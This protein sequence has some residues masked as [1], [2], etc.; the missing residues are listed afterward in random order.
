MNG[1]APPV[2][3]ALRERPD[4]PLPRGRVS[5]GRDPVVAVAADHA[6]PEDAVVV[7]VRHGSA[8]AQLRRAAAVA[9]P[10]GEP[11]RW[12]NARLPTVADGDTVDYRAE[13]LRHGRRLATLPTDGTWLRVTGAPA[14][15]APEPGPGWPFDLE[16]FATFTASGRLEV[17]GET[18]EG[19]RIDFL[20]SGGQVAGPGVD[21]VMQAGGGD[22]LRVRRDG[23]AVLDIRAA[24]R[25][26]DGAMISYRATGVLE[27]GPDGHARAVGGRLSGTAPCYVTPTFLTADPR[28]RWLNRV[29]GFGIG[30]ALLDE[31][32]V[33]YDVHLPR[34]GGSETIQRP[35]D[36]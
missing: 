30:R 17:I 24:Y 31:A 2:D 29:Q 36:A 25:T 5:A 32:R 8:P 3:P 34:V 26:G 21:G 13:L 4:Q 23:V 28:W 22:W 7:L 35:T 14:L 9:A 19:H 15:A 20:V 10:A 6:H 33:C 18:P 16:F 11:V 12:F 27:L 1:S